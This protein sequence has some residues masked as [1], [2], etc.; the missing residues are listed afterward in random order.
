M[1][2]IWDYDIKKLKKS[3]WGRKLIIERQIDRGIYPSSKEKISLKQVKKYWN[4]LEIDPMRRKLLQ[5]LIW[6]K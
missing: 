3:K 4:I 6:G 1:P 2:F 5:L